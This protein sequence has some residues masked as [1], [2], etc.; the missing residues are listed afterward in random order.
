MNKSNLNLHLLIILLTVLPLSLCYSAVDD[1]TLI[2]ANRIGMYIGNNGVLANDFFYETGSSYAGLF[3]NNDFSTALVFA[4]GLWLVGKV[5]EEVRTAMADYVVG[6]RYTEFTPGPADGNPSDSLRWHVYKI[7]SEDLA[8]PGS[9][10]INWPADLGA[11][12]GEDNK[13]LLIGDQTV[14]SVYNDL[15]L[16][17][18]TLTGDGDSALGAEVRQLAWA[19]DKKKYLGD[20]VFVQ[21]EIENKSAKAWDS[22]YI[23]LWGDPDIGSPGND[24]IGSRES[25]PMM[26]A[27]SSDLDDELLSL[28]YTA[29]GFMILDV[30]TG[31]SQPYES[32]TATNLPLS[33]FFPSTVQEAHY[34]LRGLDFNGNPYIDPT[35][36][37]ETRFPYGG[38]PRYQVGWLDRAPDDERTMISNGPYRIKPG[39]VLT[40]TAAFVAVAAPEQS[41]AFTELFAL[42]EKVDDWQRFGIDG[43]K[44]STESISGRIK[45]T[46]FQP[47][48][49][50]WIAPVSFPND[51]AGIG[52][53]RASQILG[54]SVKDSLLSSVEL[55]F[56]YDSTQNAYY[57]IHNDTGWTYSGYYPVPVRAF[58]KST[59]QQLNLIFMSADGDDCGHC[60]INSSR[61]DDI[62]RLIVLNS[63]YSPT[64]NQKYILENPLAEFGGLDLMYYLQY[65]IDPDALIYNIAE[66]QTLDI[67]FSK[68][69][70]STNEHK[71]DFDSVTVGVNRKL[72][73][74]LSSEYNS[75]MHLVADF[76]ASLPYN[77]MQSEYALAGKTE[78]PVYIDYNPMNASYSFLYFDLYNTDFEETIDRISL[79]GVGKAWPMEGDYNFNGWVDPADVVG[80]LGY[81]YRGME[82][83]VVQIDLD[84]DDSGDITLAD[85]VYLINL[86]FFA[87]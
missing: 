42:S 80:Y 19:Y 85:V 26:F 24:L 55:R 72:G 22:L 71:L 86:L 40:V 7:S 76:R 41:E 64:S 9:D 46:I 14:F 58:K 52:I 61:F 25:P 43:I 2:D 47:D 32:Y 66:G 8:A 62:Y 10:Y 21:F 75:P 5:G 23:G 73:F 81:L 20:V 59:D 48:Y 38:D 70:E 33:Q 53:G 36:G 16:A 83:P 12:L 39:G 27:Y 77:L 4:S 82:L 6:R 3:Y 31:Q 56:S 29:V 37:M 54:S 17:R 60:F 79:A 84:L 51:F 34:K 65:A 28:G 68:V 69:S 87:H 67:V 74:F 63:A 44:Y 57:Y 1:D 11:P 35:T 18:H 78:T 49:Q 15:D 50:N 45:Q 13:P 30:Q